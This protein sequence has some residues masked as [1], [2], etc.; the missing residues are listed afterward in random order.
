MRISKTSLVANMTTG[1]TAMLLA[2]H[3]CV[4]IVARAPCTLIFSAGDWEAQA[5][6]LSYFIMNLGAEVKVISESFRSFASRKTLAGL[7]LQR[8]PRNP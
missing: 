4:G 6:L 3:I 1:L 5:S 7:P 8:R 2:L